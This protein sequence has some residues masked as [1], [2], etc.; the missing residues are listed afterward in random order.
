MD[1][2]I[3]SAWVWWCFNR[4]C[5]LLTYLSG[6]QGSNHSGPKQFSYWND[7]KGGTWVAQLVK[8]Q[9]LNSAQVMIS[10]LWDRVPCRALYWVWSLVKILSLPLPCPP[11]F[12]KNEM[13]IKCSA[14]WLIIFIPQI[15]LSLFHFS[16]NP[17]DFHWLLLHH[18]EFQTK[19]S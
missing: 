18:Q 19:Q 2:L 17:I 8:N 6:D 16:H 15:C 5:Q 7:H 4:R 14:D 13:I 11:S 3:I 1:N 10:M 9:T 12:K